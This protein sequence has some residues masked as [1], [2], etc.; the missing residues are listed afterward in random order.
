MDEINKAFDLF[1]QD[2]KDI[3]PHDFLTMNRED[4]INIK[5]VEIIPPQIGKN[6]F[7][8]IRIEFKTPLYTIR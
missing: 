3:S 1:P 8:K 2:H 6:D 7:G 4:R 5:S